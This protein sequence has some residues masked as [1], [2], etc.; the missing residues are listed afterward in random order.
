M[1]RVS[2]KKRKRLPGVVITDSSG[3]KVTFKQFREA[4]ETAMNVQAFSKKYLLSRKILT[5]F[6]V[7]KGIEKEILH[8]INFQGDIYFNKEEVK[9]FL[10]TLV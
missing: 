7:K 9:K 4:N 3:E 8:P 6:Q 10:S 1:T 2:F 5:L